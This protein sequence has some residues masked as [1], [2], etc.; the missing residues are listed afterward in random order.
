MIPE[1]LLRPAILC[2]LVG[3]ASYA[4][5]AAPGGSGFTFGLSGDPSG[6]GGA[7]GAASGSATT[8]AGA[9]ESAGVGFFDAGPGDGAG[10][11]TPGCAQETQFVYTLTAF[12]ELYSF[13]PPSLHFTLIGV[14][15]CPTA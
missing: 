2:A 14:L 13:D 10:G 3:A 7:G 1:R 11:S 5:T 6:P 4:C 8:G 12:N 15:D 9:S